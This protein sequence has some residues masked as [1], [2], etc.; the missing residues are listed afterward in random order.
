[1]EDSD[2]LMFRNK[3]YVITGA[4]GGIGSHLVKSLLNLKAKIIAVDINENNLDK[5]LHDNKNNPNLKIKVSNLDSYKKCKSIISKIKKIDGFIHLAGLFKKDKLIVGDT[6]NIYNDVMNANFK[7]GYTMLIACLPSMKKAEKSKAIFISSLA[8]NKGSEDYVVY[9]AS[10]GA[11]VGMIR[12]LSK[13]LAPKIT[14]NALAPGLTETAMIKEAV[15]DRGIKNILSQIPLKRLGNAV[16]IANIIK[17]F[18]SDDADYITGQ[19][20][21]V[22]GGRTLF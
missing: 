3:T 22:D 5:L 1:M 2:L 8:F 11:I 19:V 18:L 15:R 9:S 17:F 21:N 12:A 4:A 13:K 14:V 6:E 20:I 10:K 7:N 16:E